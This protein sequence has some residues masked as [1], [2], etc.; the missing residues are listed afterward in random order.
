M[1]SSLALAVVTTAACADGLSDRRP[2]DQTVSVDDNGEETGEDNTSEE[3]SDPSDDDTDESEDAPVRPDAEPGVFDRVTPS[4]IS[5]HVGLRAGT[6]NGVYASQ[7][8]QVLYLDS[9]AEEAS[10][11]TSTLPNEV[12]RE[13]AQLQPYIYDTASVEGETYLATP[14]GLLVKTDG[15]WRQPGP[16]VKVTQIENVGGRL[17]IVQTCKNTSK[18]GVEVA[19]GAS[20]S[21]RVLT[22]DDGGRSWT[23][24]S[25][26]IET[27]EITEMVASEQGITLINY[28]TSFRLQLGDGTLR[29]TEPFENSVREVVRVRSGPSETRRCVAIEDW[30]YSEAYPVYV[31]SGSSC[32]DWKRRS[33]PTGEP[34]VDV[35][36]L[37]DR[38][39][40]VTLSGKLGRLDVS[41]D[42]VQW[43]SLPAFTNYYVRPANAKAEIRNSLA[44]SQGD[45]FYSTAKSGIWRFDPAGDRWRS[46][47]PSQAPQPRDAR[48][49]VAGDSLWM[50]STMAYRTPIGEKDWEQVRLPAPKEAPVS[51]SIETVTSTGST[52][53]VGTE[54]GE[55]YVE[56]DGD[57]Q[58]LEHEFGHLVDDKFQGFEDYWPVRSI[59]ASGDR[60]F[61]AMEGYRN[62]GGR[63]S[64]EMVPLKAPMHPLGG[65]LFVSTDGGESWKAFH[66]GL[67]ERETPGSWSDEQKKTGLPSVDDF[68]VVGETAFAT[69]E[70][71]KE[72]RSGFRHRTARGVYRRT[73]G[74]DQWT[75]I[76]SRLGEVSSIVESPL[77]EAENLKVDLRSNGERVVVTV[78]RNNV[79]REKRRAEVELLVSTDQGES[80]TSTP[81]PTPEVG[82]ADDRQTIAKAFVLGSNQIY[83]LFGYP[84]TDLTSQTPVDHLYR[85]E[86]GSDGWTRVTEQPLRYDN[87]ASGPRHPFEL[88]L[89]DTHVWLH[90]SMIDGGGTWR[91]KRP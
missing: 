30:E 53:Y 61:V 22:S 39:Y 19:C 50:L 88:Q 4:P 5:R 84:R 17:A 85:W 14:S 80:W 45:L 62:V 47:T 37:Q 89:T 21:Y 15:H 54:S 67:P 11:Q 20:F 91:V 3:T 35:V 86:F 52:T 18:F 7:G 1:I 16:A 57:L 8:D 58:L 49:E 64:G 77:R 73:P 71:R 34:I 29:T 74:A 81:L 6:P 40:A 33:Y 42:E 46:V 82:S 87:F 26:K 90:S 83:G 66:Q 44:A 75:A 9:S 36:A 2:G 28:P 48:L 69:T 60:L 56:R 78:V 27:A 32:S 79:G 63:R 55:L 31:A 68:A 23:S 72:D 13:N 38:I 10:W 65:G 43:T 41:H 70:I 12:E 51:G 24:R 76:D 25:P 59:R